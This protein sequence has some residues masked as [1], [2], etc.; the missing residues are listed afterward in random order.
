MKKKAGTKRTKKSRASTQQEDSGASKDGGGVSKM[1]PTTSNA[2]APPT[3]EGG[4]VAVATC[5]KNAKE[6]VKKWAAR[7]LD[8]G[9]NGLREEFAELKRYCPPDMSIATFQAHWDA[10]RNRYK[11]VPCQDK[12]RIILKWPGQQHD[13][14]HAK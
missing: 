10:G 5:A 11:D 2:P 1:Q 4:K 7:A 9:V 14:I 3:A 12:L 13:Y 6:E 8:K